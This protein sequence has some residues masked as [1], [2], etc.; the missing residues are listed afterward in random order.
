[1][2]RETLEAKL[3]IEEIAFRLAFHIFRMSQVWFA[4]LRRKQELLK[5]EGRIDVIIFEI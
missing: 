1:M 2:G 3:V 5:E 4:H